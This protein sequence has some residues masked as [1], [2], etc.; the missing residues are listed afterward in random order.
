MQYSSYRLGSQF[1]ARSRFGRLKLSVTKSVWVEL[2]RASLV[3][4]SLV[5]SC[6]M[7]VIIRIP[8]LCIR[9]LALTDDCARSPAYRRLCLPTTVRAHPLTDDCAY[10][11]LF[12]LTRLSM[13]VRAHPL[14]DDCARSPAYRQAC[15]DHIRIVGM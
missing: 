8:N 11:R 6:T 15:A 13:T 3:H 9:A 5:P 1:V 12:A 4:S 2:G 10:R 7:V 14:T